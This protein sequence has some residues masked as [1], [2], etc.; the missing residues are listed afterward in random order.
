MQTSLMEWRSADPL[1]PF[2]VDVF[3]E[4]QREVV[5]L[6][7]TGPYPRFVKSTLYADMLEFLEANGML[8]RPRHETSVTQTNP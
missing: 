6:M 7:R 2:N 1:P 4:A 3:D 8:L 5:L